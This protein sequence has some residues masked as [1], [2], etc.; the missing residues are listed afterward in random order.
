MSRNTRFP[1][2]R[3]VGS[4]LLA[5][6][7]LAPGMAFAQS[8]TTDAVLLAT[9]PE[10]ERLVLDVSYFGEVIAHPGMSVG[11]DYT[12][13]SRAVRIARFTEEARFKRTHWFVGGEAAGYRHRGNHVG[14]LLGG[15]AGIRRQSA[16]FFLF[17]AMLGASYFHKRLD[18]TTYEVNDAGEFEEVRFKGRPKFSPSIAFGVGQ[19]MPWFL[20]GALGWHVRPGVFFE[21]PFNTT[22]LPHP[23]VQVG[24]NYRLR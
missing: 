12:L 23:F 14:L 9:P 4:L 19:R 20:D 13:K 22:V 17:E 3:L 10:A 21:I 24:I 7:A 8:A 16:R 6:A 18:G 2:P 5:L 15:R 11:L 1:E